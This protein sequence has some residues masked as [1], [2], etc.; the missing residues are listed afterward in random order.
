LEEL[1]RALIAQARWADALKRTESA[2]GDDRRLRT[3]RGLA[4]LEAGQLAKAR[5]ELAATS[6]N[7]KVPAEAAIYLAMVDA[8]QGQRELAR[9]VLENAAKT[10][11]GRAAVHV[12]L[13]RLDLDE[14]KQKEAMAEFALAEADP[15]DWEGACGLGRLYLKAG[16]FS[17]AHQHL[18]LAV[19]RNKLH[20][21]ARAGLGQALIGLGEPAR[22]KLELES[23]LGLAPGY[24]AALR[25]LARLLLAQGKLDEARQQA[26]EAQRAEPASTDGAQLTGLLTVA[27]GNPQELLKKLERVAKTSPRD[28]AGYC[29]LGETLVKLGESAAA[30]KAFE[31]AL[32]IDSE[33]LRGRL[34]LVSAALPKGAKGVLKES[35]LLIQETDQAAGPLKARAHALRARVLLALG[36]KEQ[37]A[38][39]AKRAV[40]ADSS[41]ADARLARGLVASAEKDD[42]LAIEELSRAL[43]VDPIVADAH[44]ALAASLMRDPDML[45]RAQF[46]VDAYLRIAPKGPDAAMAKKIAEVI[47]KKLAD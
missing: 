24:P 37:A 18:T 9:Q 29:E 28:P 7:G 43:T 17:E 20:A 14:G 8:A 35:E 4:Y 6:R 22:A 47:R 36:E 40:E 23:A 41:S 25:G 32:K 38:A 26:Q 3:L 10:S 46:E 12:A 31:S 5:E 13:G 30:K 39:A 42:A 1:A 15:R 11:K 45:E 21:E 19:S 16:Q 2:S 27:G 33:N 44:L 34:G